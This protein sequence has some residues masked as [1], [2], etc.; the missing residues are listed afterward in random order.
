MD[1]LDFGYLDPS[2]DPREHYRVGSEL[3]CRSG[4]N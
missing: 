4:I 2:R 1:I 3:F